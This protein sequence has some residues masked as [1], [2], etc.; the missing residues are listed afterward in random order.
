MTDHR[1]YIDDIR[2]RRRLVDLIRIPSVTGEEDACIARLAEWLWELGVEVDHWFEGIADMLA[3]PDYPGHEVERAWLPV[4]VGVV[5]GRKPGPTVVLTG[6]VDVVPPGDSKQWSRDPYSGYM[7]G[8]TIYGRGASDMKSGIVSA[9]E[10][11][12]AFARG[13]RDFAGRVVFVAVPAEEDSGLGTLAAIRRGWNPDAVVVTEPTVNDG[14]PALVVA[15]AGAM[16]FLLEVTGLSAHASRRHLG[17]SALDH[18]WAIHKALRE[19][20]KLINESEDHPLMQALELPYAT[21][22]GLVKGGE[23]S[24]SVMDRLTA[25]IRV[26][27]PLNETVKQAWQRIQRVIER[28]TK[29]SPWLADNPPRARLIASGFGS[30]ETPMD[31]PLVGTLT[32]AADSVFG[33]TRVTAAPYGCDMSAWVRLTGASTVIYGPGDIYWAHSA[34][35]RVSLEATQKVSRVLVRTVEQLLTCS[36]AELNLPETASAASG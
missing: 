24:S 4:V 9:L 17:E 36:P 29:D 32:E 28:A 7:D 12:E 13:P 21:N 22:V 15:H 1:E 19:D 27:V 3:D 16:S 33:D 23:W 20:E 6:H 30:A 26:G 11:F 14:K 8:D 35:E 31:H 10:A 5:R 2:I 25:E 34:D 18:Y